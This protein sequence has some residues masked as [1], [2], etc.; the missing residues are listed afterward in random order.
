[1]S[2]PTK[3][4]N[5]DLEFG[6]NLVL[7]NGW[8]VDASIGKGSYSSNHRV[9][10]NYAKPPGGTLEA[11][12]CETNVVDNLGNDRTMEVAKNLGLPCEGKGMTVIPY[13]GITDWL[14]VVNYV[15][16]QARIIKRD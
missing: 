5:A 13:I 7:D 14:R 3:A 11:D 16:S 9:E 6:I 12:T 2:V 15:N 1:M 4:F 10:W 8:L